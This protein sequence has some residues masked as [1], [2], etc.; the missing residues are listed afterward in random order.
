MNEVL[1][2]NIFFI[3]ASVATVVFSIIVCFVLYQVYK[4][5]KLIRS[6]L[7]RIE[8][9]SEVVAQD[10][11]DLRESLKNGGIFGRVMSF[12]LGVASTKQQKRKSDK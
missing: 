7:E 12:I 9:A 1:H 11:S 4:V 2:A 5:V 3:I 6:V 8:S 10:I